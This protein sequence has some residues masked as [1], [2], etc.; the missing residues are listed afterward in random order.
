MNDDWVEP[1]D[2]TCDLIRKLI[3]FLR[4]GFETRYDQLVFVFSSINNSFVGEYYHAIVGDMD[5]FITCTKIVY[6]VLCCPCLGMIRAYKIRGL[7]KRNIKFTKLMLSSFQDRSATVFKFMKAQS[8][9]A[10]FSSV[11]NRVHEK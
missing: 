9:P 5:P 8:D 10:G 4:Y 7:R 2:R 3:W 6:K 1:Q 11:K